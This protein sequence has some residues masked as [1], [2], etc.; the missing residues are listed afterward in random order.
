MVD[1][2]DQSALVFDAADVLRRV[3]EM[4]DL[5]ADTLTVRQELPDL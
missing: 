1:A 2:A 4:G 5:Y 3:D